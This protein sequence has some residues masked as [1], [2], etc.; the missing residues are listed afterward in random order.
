MIGGGIAGDLNHAIKQITSEQ[1]NSARNRH[2]GGRR[3]QGRGVV[4]GSG[5]ASGRS[6]PDHRKRL[7]VHRLARLRRAREPVRGR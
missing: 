7:T 3:G 2:R 5:L 1:T 4:P 6:A